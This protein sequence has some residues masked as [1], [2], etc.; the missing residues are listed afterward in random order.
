MN[1]KSFP[2]RLLVIIS[3]SLLILYAVIQFAPSAQAPDGGRGALTTRVAAITLP[4]PTTAT[5]PTKIAVSEAAAAQPTQIENG[6]FFL[7]ADREGYQELYAAAQATL[8]DSTQWRQLT[9]G[10]APARAPALSHDGSKLAFQSRK[11]GNWEIYVLDVSSGAIT[12]V[13]NDLAYDGAPTWSADDKELAFESYR[14]QDLDIWKMSA[15]GSKPINLTPKS[16]TYDYAPAWSPDGKTIL[17]TS[18]ETGNKQLFAISPDG[19]N[20][21][22]LSNDRFHDEQAAWSP[23]GKRIAFVSNREACAETVESTLEEPPLQ[24][25]VDSGNCQRRG[26][27]VADFAGS[28][29]ATAALSNV[30]QLTFFGR[31]LAPAWSPD[32]SSIVFV[33]TRATRNPLF[34]VP[35]AGG[36][37]QVLDDDT[38]WIS[39]AVWAEGPLPKIGTAPVTQK[40]LYV[41]KPVPSNPSEGTVYDFVNMKDVYLAPSYG[42]VSS[43]VSESFR[44]LR[45]RVIS[46]SGID[47]LDTLSDMTRFISY[48]CDNTCDTLSWHK[49]GRA[50]DTLLTKPVQGREAMVLVREDTNAEVYWRI[51]LRA[52]KQDGSQGEPLTAAPWNISVNA[53]ANLA[54]GMGGIETDVEYGYFVD[55]SDLA[56]KYGW[57]RI[58]SHDD[59]EFDWRNNREAL[60]Y[61]HFQKEDGLN[62]W[63][64][65]QE[66]YAPKQM[67]DTFDWNSIVE[68]LGRAPSRT[69]LKDIPPAPDA[70][71]WFALVPR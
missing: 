32:G 28:N 47:F 52:A 2:V 66:V 26:V 70:W 24:G 14:A 35:S 20:V 25:A 27:F 21:R 45:Q 49:S 38:V 55:L 11:D 51:Y 48:V 15:D 60:E 34:V 40:P 53:R 5:N 8:H 31:D 36:L 6:A 50:V 68:D 58:S 59:T 71:N 61:W 23:D 39:S 3:L 69:Y 62:W 56:R 42:I 43:A 54:P 30:K 13:T 46:E 64:A 67:S 41:E 16:S 65:M 33:S 22:N 10:Y 18:W 12:R 37:A 19:T 57:N 7:S 9:S 17:Y 44:A 4:A 1:T 63:Q 29:P